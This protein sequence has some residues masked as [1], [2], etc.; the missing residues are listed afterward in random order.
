MT[1]PAVAAALLA[2]AACDTPQPSP[3]ST[4]PAASYVCDNGSTVRAAYGAAPDGTPTATLLVDGRP[5]ALRAVDAESGA[6]FGGEQGL[7]AGTSLVWTTTG[8][9]GR[10][11]ALPLDHT[12]DPA[13]DARRI[14]SCRAVY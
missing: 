4:G 6:R 5:F 9:E 12:A 1:R 10:L 13:R 14:A 7:L 11:E 3:G 2:L 8:E